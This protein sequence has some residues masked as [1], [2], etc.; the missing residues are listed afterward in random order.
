MGLGS[1]V[2]HGMV[3]M[4]NEAGGKAVGLTDRDGGLI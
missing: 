1:E 2:R 4:M 3:G